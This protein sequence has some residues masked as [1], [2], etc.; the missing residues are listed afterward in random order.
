MRFVTYVTL[1]HPLLPYGTTAI[2]HPVSD[3]I[4]QS[5]AIYDIRALWLSCV[6]GSCT[7]PYGNSGVKRLTYCIV[8][9]ENIV[10][11]GRSWNRRDF[12]F[13]PPVLWCSGLIPGQMSPS[14]KRFSEFLGGRRRRFSEFLGGRKRFSEFLGGRKRF[15]E[16]LGGKKRFS[17]FLGG[18]RNTL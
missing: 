12:V 17:E 9:S 2:K 15:S 7:H 5:F 10:R 4:K 18:K 11:T 1:W 6:H 8:K 16:F 14:D 13:T 3:R